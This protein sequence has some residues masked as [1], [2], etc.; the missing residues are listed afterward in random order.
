MPQSIFISHTHTDEPIADAIDAASKTLYGEGV[1]VN[2]STKKELS[3]GIKPG[4][5]WYHWIGQQ[6]REAKASLILLTPRIDPEAVA[7][8]GSR[9]GCRSDRSD[10]RRGTQALPDYLWAHQLR[11]SVS[12]WA[13]PDDGRPQEERHRTTCSRI[14]PACSSCRATSSSTWAGGSMKHARVILTGRQLRFGL[15][16][17]RHRSRRSGMAGADRRPQ[18]GRTFLGN[19]RAARLAECRLWARG[20]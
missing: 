18:K 17:A 8:V 5:D 6:V 15:A 2:Y 4:D 13:N 7:A 20:R 14:W 1:V 11:R 9:R 12:L 19:R 16:P 10:R 3:G